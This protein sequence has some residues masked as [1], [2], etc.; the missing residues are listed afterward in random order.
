MDLQ[1]IY[2]LDY[3]RMAVYSV[4]NRHVSFIGKV[5]FNGNVLETLETILERVELKPN[6]IIA[7][8]IKT[9]ETKDY[10]LTKTDQVAA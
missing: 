9:G 5:T 6:K 10:E 3:G 2:E 7:T 4:D 8:N 1:L